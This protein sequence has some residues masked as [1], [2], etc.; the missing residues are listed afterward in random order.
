VVQRV[1]RKKGRIEGGT[2]RG[3]GEKRVLVHL[4]NG[5]RVVG[6]NATDATHCVKEEPVS[7]EE[8]GTGKEKKLK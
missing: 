6:G 5:A 8:S 7:I 3:R 4:T 1:L 2:Q